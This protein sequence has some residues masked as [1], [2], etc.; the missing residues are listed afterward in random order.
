MV[1]NSAYPGLA[2]MFSH[3]LS[4]IFQRNLPH[5]SIRTTQELEEALASQG[6]IGWNTFL[7]GMPSKQLVNLQDSFLQAVG[8][9]GQAGPGLANYS[10][11]FG[12]LSI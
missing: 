4:K 8:K 12:T 11:N 5:P 9:K 6:H 1:F 10:H 7:F 2:K 3:E